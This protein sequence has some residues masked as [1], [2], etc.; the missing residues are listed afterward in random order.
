[1][2]A[3]ERET[4][5][6]SDLEKN[7]TSRSTWLRLVFMILF[8]LIYGLTRFVTAFVVVIQ[9][10]YVL[11]TGNRN[12]QLRQFGHSLAIYSYQ[13]VDYLTFNTE[14]KPFPFDSVWP[15]SLPHEDEAVEDEDGV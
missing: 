8:A 5:K 6:P 10:L 15:M 11:I 3:D 13:I 14:T 9:F 2:D 12:E 7:V 1:M 4:R